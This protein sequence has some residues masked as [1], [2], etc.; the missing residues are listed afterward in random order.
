MT[1]GLFHVQKDSRS[2]SWI[3]LIG[4]ER[5]KSLDN[6]TKQKILF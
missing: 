6:L 5:K 4:Q 3:S 1:F 2:T